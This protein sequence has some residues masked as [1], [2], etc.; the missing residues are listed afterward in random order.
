MVEI[1]YLLTGL[2]IGF[3]VSM[4]VFIRKLM[5]IEEWWKDTWHGGVI[6]ILGEFARE[7]KRLKD[8]HNK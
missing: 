6:E 1:L 2:V 5:R 7:N 8:A 3:L 4:F